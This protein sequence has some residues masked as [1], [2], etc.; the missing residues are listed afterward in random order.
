MSKHAMAKALRAWGWTCERKRG[1]PV[2]WRDPLECEQRGLRTEDAYLLAA[3]RAAYGIEA[4]PL[5]R[6]TP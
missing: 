5:R 3:T 2:W 1:E 4:K 6:S